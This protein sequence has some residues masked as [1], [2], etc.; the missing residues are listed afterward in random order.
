MTGMD[1]IA[2]VSQIVWKHTVVGP[3]S[4]AT[5]TCV[6]GALWWPGGLQ[7]YGFLNSIPGII[8]SS[9]VPTGQQRVASRASWVHFYSSDVNWNSE[10]HLLCQLPL[11]I[12]S[13][14]KSR[15][16]KE[17]VWDY[18]REENS[19]PRE[20]RPVFQH[21]SAKLAVWLSF[22]NQYDPL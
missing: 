6:V 4:S 12:S 1:K 19:A 20:S 2:F 7:A 11:G 18:S 17:W 15:T 22:R 21:N 9:L 16:T 3:G 10:A 13:L 14:P 8:Q 5:I